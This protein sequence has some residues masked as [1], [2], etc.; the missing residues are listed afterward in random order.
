[1][2][3]KRKPMKKQ[4]MRGKLL[5]E[6]DRLF[7]LVIAKERGPNCE[8]HGKE[9]DRVG[10]M[11]ILSKQ[12]NPR[13]R[14]CRENIVRAGWFCSHYWT[15]HNP[16]D[17]RAVFAKR[18]IAEIKGVDYMEVLWKIEQFIGKHDNLYL[19]AKIAEFKKELKG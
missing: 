16:D 3:F 6:A 5:A 7:S 1:M 15:H 11:H 17:P 14:Y 9:C 19:M 10:N 18:R 13:L 8:I 4:S 12:S 2:W